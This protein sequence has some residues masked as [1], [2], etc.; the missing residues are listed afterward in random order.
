MQQLLTSNTSGPADLNPPASSEMVETS[1]T[2]VP[3]TAPSKAVKL[4]SPSGAENSWA[5]SPCCENCEEFSPS[6]ASSTELHPCSRCTDLKAKNQQPQKK[7]SKLKA[8]NCELKKARKVIVNV[9][10]Y[11]FSVSDL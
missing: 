4:P 10:S 8:K 7:V 11:F 1:L 9:S 6:P 3:V 2:I 5:A